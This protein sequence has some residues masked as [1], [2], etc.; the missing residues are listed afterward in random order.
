GER[1]GYGVTYPVVIVC[2]RAAH[3]ILL[4]ACI[5]AIVAFAWPWRGELIIYSAVL[6]H[7]PTKRSGRRSLAGGGSGPDGF[8]APCS[9]GS[10]PGHRG[11][12]P[13]SAPDS[14]YF[15]SDCDR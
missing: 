15:R 6:W 8:P 3:V 2:A 9:W 1:G 5:G 4:D 7:L 14:G 13:A 10:A 12:I 11:Q